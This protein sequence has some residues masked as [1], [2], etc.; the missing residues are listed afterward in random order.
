MISS[1]FS[2][3]FQALISPDLLYNSY[4]VLFLLFYMLS[5]RTPSP[6]SFCFY[7]K[8]LCPF[9]SLAL[10]KRDTTLILLTLLRNSRRNDYDKSY[11]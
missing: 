1:Y 8:L 2:V 9:L 10:P 11:L 7:A 6:F 4:F 3:I 5:F